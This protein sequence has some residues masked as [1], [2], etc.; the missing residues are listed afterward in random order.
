MADPPQDPP[1]RPRPRRPGEEEPPLHPRRRHGQ[2]HR[3]EDRGSGAGRQAEGALAEE[4]PASVRGA[5][6]GRGQLLQGHQGLARSE[7][8]EQGSK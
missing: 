1:L 4:A 2:A 8:R 3:E 5:E 6:E 7:A